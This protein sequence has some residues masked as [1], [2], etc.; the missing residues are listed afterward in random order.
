MVRDLR[1]QPIKR[2]GTVLLSPFALS[3]DAK[4]RSRRVSMERLPCTSRTGGRDTF[5]VRTRKVSKGNRPGR[6]VATRLPS[7]LAALRG[8]AHGPSL[9]LRSSADILSRAPSGQ[10]CS[11]RCV[12]T[13]QRGF[14]E[15]RIGPYKPRSLHSPWPDPG[16]SSPAS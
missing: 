2:A 13:L 9:A 7:H 1:S 4:H 10:P 8:L 15:G 5:L 16:L 11:R 6:V 14:Q 3:V 12:G